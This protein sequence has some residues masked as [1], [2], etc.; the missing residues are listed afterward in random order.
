MTKPK[1]PQPYRHD[2]APII[3]VNEVISEQLTVGQKA[4]DWVV[5]KV[6]SW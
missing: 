5:A 1:F 2:H 3:N 4:A 6:G